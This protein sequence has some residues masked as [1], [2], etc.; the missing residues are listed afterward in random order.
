M[1]DGDIIL[2]RKTAG[3]IQTSSNGV[4]VC[5]WS[6]PINTTARVE[7][8]CTVQQVYDNTAKSSYKLI[9]TVR[10][11]DADVSIVSGPT[12]VNTEESSVAMTVTLFASG[13]T[14][15]VITATTDGEEYRVTCFME[16]YVVEQFGNY[17]SLLFGGTNEYVN[18]GNVLNFERTDAFSISLWCKTTT[19][20]KFLIAKNSGT[21]PYAGYA[22]YLN[23]GTYTG[24][25]TFLLSNTS[26]TN[27]F[28]VFTTTATINNGNWHHCIC[29]YDGSSLVSGMHIYI[30]GEIVDLTIWKNTLTGSIITTAPFR[31]GQWD[32][33]GYAF[34]GNID[35]TSVYNK[36]LSLPEV[37]AIYNSGIPT[38][39]KNLSSASNMVAYWRCG[40]GDTYPTILDHSDSGF[41]GTMTNM[42]SGDIIADAPP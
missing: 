29:T 23:G 42:E 8:H 19:N 14:L 10:R 2:G 9:A 35:E 1:A 41:N 27:E 22:V 31:I 5:V 24:A 38:N 4:E 11:D 20:D 36:E 17:Y 18:M 12:V 26:S 39:L 13:S 30:D 7:V 34:E 3:S 28:Q 21:A 25:I 6:I 32:G 37:E 33:T 16:I 40:D 15:S